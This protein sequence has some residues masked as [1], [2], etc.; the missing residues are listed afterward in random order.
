MNIIQGITCTCI[1]VLIGSENFIEN[2]II[3]Y[4]D[5]GVLNGNNRN[6]YRAQDFCLSVIIV[7]IK[8]FTRISFQ[9]P[10]IF[11]KV[12]CILSVSTFFIAKYMYVDDMISITVP[13]GDVVLVEVGIS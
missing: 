2:V 7:K 13:C 9:L 8:Q 5:R 1:F 10:I 4:N 3:R 6:G 12:H 11:E